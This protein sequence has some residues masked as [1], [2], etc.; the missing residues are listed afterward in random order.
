MSLVR[1]GMIDILRMDDRVFVRVSFT[2]S[3]PPLIIPPW[4]ARTP[5]LRLSRSTFQ[6]DITNLKD[7]RQCERSPERAARM[8]AI[9]KSQ[10]EGAWDSDSSEESELA[11]LVEKA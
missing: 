4:R 5:S 11:A 2:Q 1:K 9:P 7:P 3:S 8:R 6:D 10:E